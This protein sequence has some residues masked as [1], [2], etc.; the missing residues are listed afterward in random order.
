[1]SISASMV[2]KLR[3]A[4]G[5]GMMACKKALI[6]ADGD[7]EKAIENLRKQGQATAT[8]RA[9]KAAKEGKIDII[10]EGNDTLVFEVNSETDFVARNDDFLA[11]VADLGKVLLEKKPTDMESAM[12]LTS[13]RFNDQSVEAKTLELVGKIG[14]KIS[15]RRFRIVTTDAAKERAFSYIHGQ[16]KIGVVVVLSSDKADVL[17]SGEL[18]DLGKD[19]AM[20]VAASKP[21]AIDRDSVDADLVAKE[22]EIYLGQVQNSGKPEKIWDKIV[23]GKMNKYY[24]QV[25]LVEQEFI[26]DTDICVADR[27]KQ[28]EKEKDASISVVSFVRF[29][30]GAEE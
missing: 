11:F 13:P 5:L 29:E 1:M 25:A 12:T 4:T 24:K 17:E 22:R 10:K 27:I 6:E 19:C 9:G 8:K 15:P 2:M 14:E 20:Q 21:A 7:M 23:D 18:A 26:K 3:E 28:V 30:L 16:G